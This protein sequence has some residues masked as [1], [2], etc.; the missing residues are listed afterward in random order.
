[1][2]WKPIKRVPRKIK[3]AKR[4]LG[5]VLRAVVFQGADGAVYEA[6]AWIRESGPIWQGTMYVP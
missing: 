5:L 4:K 3:K 6:Q 2:T 1:V